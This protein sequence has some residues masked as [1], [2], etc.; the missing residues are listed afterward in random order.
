[1]GLVL[2]YARL[3]KAGTWQYRRRIPTSIRDVTNQRG[4]KRL[5][6]ATRPE[7]MKAYPQLE[8]EFVV[9][10]RETM[11]RR[12]ADTEAPVRE[13]TSL[14][15]YRLAERRAKELAEKVAVT[16]GAANYRRQI[17]KRHQSAGNPDPEAVA[18]LPVQTG[19]WHIVT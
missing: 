19:Q 13:R 9:L 3:T 18:R 8:D 11:R 6:G 10:V 15:I 12:A 5:L 2:R 1:M 14:D 4:G 7:A 17:Q 16:I